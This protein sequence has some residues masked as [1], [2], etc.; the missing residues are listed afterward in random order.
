MKGRK[1]KPTVLKVISGNPGK[2]PL[3]KH[4]PQPKPDCPE[5]PDNL[6]PA[7][8]EE[9]D[10]VV[11]LLYQLGLLSGL[12]RA[13]LVAYCVAWGRWMDA[14]DALLKSGAVVMS[15]NG[16][17][18]PSPFLAVANRAMKQI[19]EFL[20]EFGMSPS[21]RTRVTVSGSQKENKF[22]GRGRRDRKVG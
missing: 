2:R 11:P 12:D 20:A 16:F 8:L 9:W 13:A 15:P 3:P 14:E 22:S 19:K 21:S 17:P 4:E 5:P 1:P 10:R 7:A 6:S 18:V